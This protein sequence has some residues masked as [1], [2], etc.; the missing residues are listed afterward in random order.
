MPRPIQSSHRE[1]VESSS[2]SWTSQD[3][4]DGL[5]RSPSPSKTITGGTPEATIVRKPAPSTRN[6][7][8]TQG[9]VKSDQGAGNIYADIYKPTPPSPI[10]KPTEVANPQGRQP[11]SAWQHGNDST[12]E[13]DDKSKVSNPALPAGADTSPVLSHDF[14]PTLV[15]NAELAAMYQERKPAPRIAPSTNKVMTRAQFERYKQQQEDDRRRGLIQDHDGSDEEINY[16]DDDE[17]E[18]DREA[19]QKRKKQEAHLAVYRQQMK[20]VT[21]QPAQPRP[22]SSVG[23]ELSSR[24]SHLMVDPAQSGK[25]SGD[26]EVDE[27]E[28]VP[29]GILAAHGFPNKNRSPSRINSPSNAN[30]GAMAQQ[31][32]GSPGSVAGGDPRR[33]SGL[34][35]FAR[36]LP[37]DPYY[38]A[39]LVNPSNRQSLALHGN[40][41]MPNVPSAPS[42]GLYPTHPAGLV[43]VMA[44]E[45]RA[46][47]MRRGSPNAQTYDL[48]P[49]PPHP[50]MPRAHTAGN[51]SM[52]GQSSMSPVTHGMPPMMFP[53]DHAQHQMSQQ[54]SQ[55]MQMQ[56]QYMQQMSQMM[57]PQMHQGQQ[58]SSMPQN[59]QSPPNPTFRPQSMPMSNTPV[60]SAQG[61][62]AMSTLNPSMA[63]WSASMPAL[64]QIN[65]TGS[66][67]APSIAPSERSNIGLASRYRPVSM[68]LQDERPSSN[69]ASTFTAST[70]RAWPQA[71]MNSRPAAHFARTPPSTMPVKQAT[72]VDE[73]DDEQGWAEMK[74]KKDKKQKTWKMRKGQ[75]TLQE[76]YTHATA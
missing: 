40:Q 45:E 65:V 57:S 76:L 67:Y 13:L 49:A 20:K 62:R 48:P 17:A 7:N 56:M 70:S 75:N 2:Y 46:R 44:G 23:T 36:N 71:E 34:P 26:E 54:L 39:S 22:G 27:D 32:A 53:G 31:Q 52:M 4:S 24:M 11:D 16:E 68:A 29:L 18:R 5:I 10:R 58:F 47:A 64:P 15:A 19:V 74:A 66:T 42:S 8:G 35:V 51:M 33:G 9:V 12:R 21:G 59:G 3:S 37:Q 72:A 63:P 25:S 43:G 41:G 60:V 6:T 55:F 61:Q 73:D 69:R 14:D 1:A 38:G 50:G 28:D 30:L